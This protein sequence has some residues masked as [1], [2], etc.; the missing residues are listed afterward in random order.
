VQL[1]TSGPADQ[2]PCADFLYGFKAAPRGRSRRR[3][4]ALAFAPAG[5]PATAAPTPGGWRERR[6]TLGPSL[7][8][9]S[10][11]ELGR[12]VPMLPLRNCPRPGRTRQGR[13]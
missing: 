13:L 8:D 12:G 10:Y 2:R 5:A 9:S 7:T 4:G 6:E 11:R 1:R 3:R